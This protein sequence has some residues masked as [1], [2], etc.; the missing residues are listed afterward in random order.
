MCI[1][2]H[3]IDGCRHGGISPLKCPYVET[4]KPQMM[5]SRVR[6]RLPSHYCGYASR[7]RDPFGSPATKEAID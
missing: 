5:M 3:W 2:L 1:R 7:A 6:G 4:A